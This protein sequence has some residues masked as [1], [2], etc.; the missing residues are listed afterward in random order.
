MLMTMMTMMIRMLII[1][2]ANNF[3]KMSDVVEPEDTYLSGDAKMTSLIINDIPTNDRS[4]IKFVEFCKLSQNELNEITTLT[5]RNCEGLTNLFESIGSLPALTKLHI[6]NCNGLTSSPVSFGS[7]P[8]LTELTIRSCKGLTNLPDNLGSLTTLTRLDINDCNGL[9]SL[10]DS[11]GGLQAL[12]DIIIHNCDGLKVLPESIGGLVALKNL[13]LY[14][15]HVLTSLPESIGGLQALTVLNI[16]KSNVLTLPVTIGLC[17]NLKS[18]YISNVNLLPPS[19]IL[20]LPNI[21][22]NYDTPDDVLCS[23]WID[24]IKISTNP[25]YTKSIAEL[26]AW[27]RDNQQKLDPELQYTLTHLI[28]GIQRRQNYESTHGPHSYVVPFFDTEMLEE[29]FKVGNIGLQCHNDLLPKK[30][31]SIKDIY[32]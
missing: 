20:L 17:L 24:K 21:S 10:P 31:L 15:C 29:A 8:A 27:S 22:V 23:K 18:I 9:T 19:V 13:Y 26:F 5:I 16:E 12:T 32:Q 30:H 7:L 2:V 25:F 3:G 28:L 6:Y 4:S 11:I 14:N 1:T